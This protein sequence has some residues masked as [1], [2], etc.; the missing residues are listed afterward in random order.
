MRNEDKVRNSPDRPSPNVPSPNPQPY[1]RAV[2]EKESDPIREDF[3]E[4]SME[5]GYQRDQLVGRD[6]DPA[7]GRE[8]RGSE[9]R[10]GSLEA[11][12]SGTQSPTGQRHDYDDANILKA[13]QEALENDNG[14]DARNIQVTV[15]GGEVTLRGF[16]PDRHELRAAESG[17]R[18]IAG[19]SRVHNHLQLRV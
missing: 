1:E 2:R 16:V 18:G 10:G 17:A 12:S 13:V 7:L 9:R 6:Y 15:K 5:R 11:E 3:G 14:V 4:G 8:G 19:V